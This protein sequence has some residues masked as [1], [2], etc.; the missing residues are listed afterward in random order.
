[1]TPTGTTPS[2]A[3]IYQR[4]VRRAL[5]HWRW[6]AV[7]IVGMLITAVTQPL[8]A[9]W[10][11]LLI[12]GSF[13]E[14]DPEL[15]R[16]MP[17]GLL[18]VF[19]L[20][21]LAS[22]LS[23]FFM[24][25]VAQ[26]V[27]HDLRLELFTKVLRLPVSYFDR[28]SSGNII[29]K[30]IYNVEQVAAASTQSLT[31]LIRDTATVIALLGWMFYLNWELTVFIL[32]VAPVI[33]GLVR[34]VSKRFRRIAHRIQG[35]V[36]DV[37]HVS[38]EAVE[39]HRVVKVFGGDAYEA[40]RFDDASR[41]YRRLQLKMVSTQAGTT[42]I[43]E[44]LVAVV[45]AGIVFMATRPDELSTISAG[46]FVSFIT[47]LLLVLQ[48]IR[49]LALINADIQRGIAAGESIFELV[50]AESETDGGTLALDRARGEVEYRD[51]GFRYADEKGD[52]LQ[53][54]S[55]RVEPGQTIALVGRSGS[56]KT[57]LANLLPRF[58]EP[59]AGSIL[60]DGVDVREYRLTDLRDQIAYVG[61]HVTLFNDSIARNIAYGHMADATE[62]Q[63]IEAAKAADAWEFISRLPQGLET[64]VGENGVLL[65]GGQRQRLAIARALLKDA[66]MLI[67]D[68]ATSALD[69]E[70]E[71]RIQGA[72]ERLFENR[73]T[74]VIAH[75][76][77]TI[78]RA[79][80]ILVLDEGRVVESGTHAELLARGGRYA[81]LHSLQ[82]HEPDA[83]PG[84][85]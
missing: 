1:M 39:G 4:L 15:I 76:L 82:F 50:D 26:Q 23:T 11:Q 67:L 32:I 44:F 84:V 58:Y 80:R 75:R 24:A 14:Q 48:P 19:F 65:S 61:Q 36:G 72:L 6:L 41:N 60:V 78:E 83:E 37:T 45:L 68:E 70:A 8:F 29:A 42:P 51:V 10:M 28:N 2:G 73:T 21:G 3:S 85:R 17:A 77:S 49:R 5:R 22:Y 43:I 57:T 52:V 47:A 55:F 54:I 9:Y 31:V 62:A 18:G 59:Q 30:L 35:S 33:A 7:A 46:T 12:D 53:G 79:D 63:I 34:W 56:G 64:Q 16:W 69:T 27:V 13:V 71:R 38:E 66:P 74:L 20:R 25:R 40:G 81:H